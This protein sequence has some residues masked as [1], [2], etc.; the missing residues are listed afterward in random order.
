MADELSR[1]RTIK[2][3]SLRTTYLFTY[4]PIKV[5]T[6]RPNYLSST[7]RPAGLATYPPTYLSTDLRSYLATYVPRYLATNQP[8]L[9]IDMPNDLPLSL[10]AYLLFL[11]IYKSI[12]IPI[13]LATKLLSY[14]STSRPVCP[15]AD[16]T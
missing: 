10:S 8:Q 1:Y 14:Q 3:F 6:C 12:I 9:A 7:Y 13:Y 2:T 5:P 15:V 11:P 16:F 4:L